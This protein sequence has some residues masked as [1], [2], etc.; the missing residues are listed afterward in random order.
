MFQVSLNI[1]HEHSVYSL[2]IRSH[3]TNQTLATKKKL[4]IPKL[5][6]IVAYPIAAV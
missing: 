5:L 1:E 2:Q 6:E 4:K 3:E